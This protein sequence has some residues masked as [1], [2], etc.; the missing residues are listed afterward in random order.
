MQVTTSKLGVIVKI[1]RT[2]SPHRCDSF[3]WARNPSNWSKAR[4]SGW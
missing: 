3:S 4:M 1:S 2:V